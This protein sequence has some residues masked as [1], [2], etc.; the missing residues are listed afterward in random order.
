MANRFIPHD[1]QCQICGTTEGCEDKYCPVEGLY[2]VCGRR[3]CCVRYNA[4]TVHQA[5]LRAG[6]VLPCCGISQSQTRPE[7]TMTVDLRLITCKGKVE[8]ATTSTV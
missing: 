1:H 6:A 3:E 2:K 7:D 8:D 4:R 5:P